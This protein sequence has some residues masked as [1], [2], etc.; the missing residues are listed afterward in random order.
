[1]AMVAR[2]IC[3]QM[4]VS[5][6]VQSKLHLSMRKSNYIESHFFSAAFRFS[7]SSQFCPVQSDP[8]LQFANSQGE[9][10]LD[11]SSKYLENLVEMFALKVRSLKRL[12]DST[13]CCY[14]SAMTTDPRVSLW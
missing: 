4:L 8:N 10:L 9:V 7:C 11:C 13:G 3:Y 12:P 1:M 5:N 14:M 2:H 6:C